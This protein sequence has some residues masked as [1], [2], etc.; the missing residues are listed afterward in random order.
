[1]EPMSPAPAPPRYW[2]DFCKEYT[3]MPHT[4]EYAY[5]LPTPT[6]ASPTP[7]VT[8]NGVSPLD[9]WFLNT[10]AAPALDAVKVDDEINVVATPGV[11]NLFNLGDIFNTAA[12]TGIS[13]YFFLDRARS[14]APPP[15][16]AGSSA[17]PPAATPPTAAPPPATRAEA[18]ARMKEKALPAAPP[19]P[20]EGTA[21]TPPTLR[22]LL[23]R[24]VAA[25]DRRPGIRRGTW[26]PAALGLPSAEVLNMAV[27]GN[28][29][30]SPDEGEFSSN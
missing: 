25:V 28:G 6:P 11:G 26:S 16:R 17:P 20:A 3:L 30:Y 7:V 5:S 19:S 29:F 22:R 12:R 13:P 24:R 15:A 8:G 27:G 10:Q 2:C 14:S 1:M 21:T 9:S 18:A 4:L 23:G